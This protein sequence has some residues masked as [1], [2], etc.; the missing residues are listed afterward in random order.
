MNKLAA[1][2][3]YIQIFFGYAKL[4][5]VTVRPMLLDLG[6]TCFSTLLHNARFRLSTRLNCS[7]NSFVRNADCF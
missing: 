3:K 1:T 2:F 7:V 6:L 4:I 5:S